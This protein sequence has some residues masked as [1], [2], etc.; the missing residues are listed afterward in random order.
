MKL[1]FASASPYVRKVRVLLH[2]TG[3]ADDV[4]LLSVKTTPITTAAKARAANP[5]GKIP[6][7]IRDEGRPIFDSRAICRYLDAR[8]NGGLYPEDRLWDV[9]TLEAM[10]DGIMD[11]AILI[12]YEG[13]LRAPERQDHG[14][15]DAQWGKVS[16]ALDA[17]ES[18]WVADLNGPRDMGQFALGCALGYLDFRHDARHWRTGR[19]ALAQWFETLATRDSMRATVPS[20]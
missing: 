5:L 3:Q 11:A 17:L 10:A 14:W 9:L 6:A 2:E 18:D 13:R 1:L 8:G 16:H 15:L 7:L 19:P 20:D 12:T 4:E